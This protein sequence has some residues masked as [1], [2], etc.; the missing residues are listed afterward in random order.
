[1]QYKVTAPYRPDLERSIRFDDPALAIAWPI[2]V[3]EIQLS[4]KDRDAP[5]LADLDTGFRWQ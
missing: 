3:A 5:L 1:V 2:A 4:D